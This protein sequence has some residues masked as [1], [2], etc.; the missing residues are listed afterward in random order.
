MITSYTKKT[1]RSLTV[2]TVTTT[3]TGTV[4]FHWYLD[5]TWL[6]FTQTP[7][8]SVHMDEGDQGELVCID[9][10]NAA[11]DGPAN[12][13]TG[14]PTRRTLWWV[15]SINQDVDYYRV[16]CGTGASEPG[17]Y[18]LLGKVRDNGAWT[19][20]FVTPVLDD[21]TN[22][23]WRIV[24]VDTAGNQGSPILLGPD[25]VV[26]KPDPPDYTATYSQATQRVAF[27][28]A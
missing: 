22:Y 17:T 6:G 3:L 21:L 23:W 25:Y 9:T 26:R 14:Y 15:R 7:E 24:P 12:A 20:E 11:F 27:A 8:F 5:G 18:T 28:A 13:P 1:Q 19:F 10:T 2:V 16:E 4:Y